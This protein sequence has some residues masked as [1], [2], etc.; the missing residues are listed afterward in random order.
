MAADV[1]DGYPHRPVVEFDG[2]EEVPSEQGASTAGLVAH[3]PPEMRIADDRA[4]D[5]TPLHACVLGPEQ[6]CLAQLTG[7]LLALPPGDGVADR[8]GERLVVDPA[9]DEVVLGS[10]V[11]GIRSDGPVHVPGQH[12]HRCTSWV[13]DDGSHGLQA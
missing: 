13:S 1:P 10:Q 9:L 5:Q 6:E 2:V 3:G 7:G 11:D 12:D 4:G 8:P